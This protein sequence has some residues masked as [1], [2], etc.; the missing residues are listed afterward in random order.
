MSEIEIDLENSY[1]RIQKVSRAGRNGRSIQITVPHVVVKRI[2]KSL[3][4]NGRYA[5]EIVSEN[6]NARIY[7]D[8][9]PGVYVEFVEKDREEADDKKRNS[10][11]WKKRPNDS[12]SPSSLRKKSER[13]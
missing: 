8:D 9:F 7:F 6:M 1:D 2:A 10:E 13:R 12:E 5:S 11:A 4:K 3:E